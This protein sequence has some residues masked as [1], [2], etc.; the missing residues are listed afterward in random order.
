MTPDDNTIERVTQPGNIELFDRKR[1]ITGVTIQYYYSC[2]REVWFY[3]HFFDPEQNTNDMKLG[4]MLHEKAYK[5]KG[6][7]SI[8]IGDS[9]VDL[10][11]NGKTIIISEVVKSSKLIQPKIKQL[12]YYL[13]LLRKQ[14]IH[15]KGLVRVPKERKK[16]TVPYSEEI[17]NEMPR[18]IQDILRIAGLPIPPEYSPKPY[19]KNCA[20][21]E[22]CEA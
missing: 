22:F 7:R 10:L 15:A 13:W 19:C 17:E 21:K 8:S 16:I 6:K 4:R 14:G 20:Y 1:R 12:Q 5:G 11:Q 9:V 3:T 2:H 18:I